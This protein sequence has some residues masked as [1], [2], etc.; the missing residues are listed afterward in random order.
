M[1]QYQR[2]DLVRGTALFTNAAGAATDPTTI[3]AT[4][5][6]PAGSA[7]AYVYG[8]DVE[9]VRDSAGAYHLDATCDLAGLWV[10]VWAGTGAVQQTAFDSWYVAD[11]P[12][13]GA[14][15][16]MADLIGD[17]RDLVGDAAGTAQVFNDRQVLRELDARRREIV[18]EPMY[19]QVRQVA[20]GSIAYYDYYA[21]CGNLETTDGGTAV[22]TI[23]DSTG[24]TQGTA[25]W[26][27]DYRR[28][29]VTFTTDRRGTAYYLTARAYDT[30]GA[31]AALLR[32]W[33]TRLAREFDFSTDGQS[34]S[35]S[36]QTR[37]LLT[38]AQEYERQSWSA[39]GSVQMLRSDIATGGVDVDRY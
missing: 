13:A 37:G 23:Q 25:G 6:N 27:A 26:S 15:V 9:L 24:A 2:G 14:R 7:T 32:Q 17:V 30:Y 36:Q 31:A 5:T 19:A 29:H 3:T 20:G 16:T 22:F 28:G 39:V 33:A 8:T 38:Q 10:E 4:R 12:S 18:F 1:N 11:A 21:G 34:F 35:R